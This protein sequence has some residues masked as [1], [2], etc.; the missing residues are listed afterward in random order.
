[1]DD[2]EKNV[3]IASLPIFRKSYEL[4]L[5][6]RR[7]IESFPKVDRQILGERM[8]S[9]SLDMLE[10]ISNICRNYISVD[11]RMYCMDKF[12]R[13]LDLYKN[14]AKLAYDTKAMSSKGIARLSLI[15]ESLGKQIG[16]WKKSISEGK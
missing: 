11:E 15:T 1:M 10:L 4:S 16:G 14:L 6:T 8:F 2:N 9:S 7:I 3:A 12:M 13:R 5:E